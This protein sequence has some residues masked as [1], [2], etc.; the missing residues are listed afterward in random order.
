MANEEDDCHFFIL[1]SAVAAEARVFGV[2]TCVSSFEIYCG[3]SSDSKRLQIV[4]IILW[5]MSAVNTVIGVMKY[6]NDGD[7]QR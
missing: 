4:T 1:L 2:T 3:D 7:A 5:E 6:Q